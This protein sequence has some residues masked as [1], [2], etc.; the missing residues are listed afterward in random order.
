MKIIG[1]YFPLIKTNKEV[2][3]LEG[4]CPKEGGLQFLMSGRCANYLA[5][6]D[7]A[8]TDEKKVA[9]VPL[10]TCETVVAPFV[11]AGYRLRFYDFQKD[12]T[13]VFSEDALSEISLISICGYYGFSRYDRS[14]VE[15]CKKKGITV[16][17]DTTHS[18]FSADGINPNCDYVVGSL[19]KWMGV[20]AG[21]FAIKTRGKFEVSPAPIHA[22]HIR[23]RTEGLKEL[24]ELS[25]I[26]GGAI[27]EARYEAAGKELWDAELLL[28]KIFDAQES[29]A[30]SLSLIH[31]FDYEALK[32]KRRENYAYLLSHAPESQRYELVFPKLDEATVPSHF[33]LYADDQAAFKAFMNTRGIH[34]TTYWPVG[35]E[36]QLSGHPEAA[37]IYAHVISLPCDQRYGTEDMQRICD[38]LKEYSEG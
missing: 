16:L 3:F 8:R 25:E 37:Y 32:K 18:I 34:A 12:M 36:V 14:F 13:P 33:T 23:M 35:P 22:E 4:L 7:I 27:E 1:G 30:L 38:A 6:Q 20:P 11:K 24:T 31:H 29:D 19:R 15:R 21:G 10:Y 2:N 9:Y 5:I 26:C 28:R 17:Q